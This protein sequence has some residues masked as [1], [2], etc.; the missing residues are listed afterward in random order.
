MDAKYRQTICYIQMKNNSV[1]SLINYIKK[2]KDSEI[3]TF[4]YT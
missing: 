1:I 4:F 3:L 2:E